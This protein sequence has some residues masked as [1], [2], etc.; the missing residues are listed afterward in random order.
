VVFCDDPCDFSSFAYLMLRLRV[1]T[2]LVAVAALPA[3]A[4]AQPAPGGC[5][6]WTTNSQQL[7]NVISTNHYLL[8]RNVQVDCNDMHFFADEVEVFSDADRVRASGHVVFVS[9]N[10][11]ISA[12]RMDFNTRTRTGTFYVA[13][14][15]ASLENRGVD[16]SYFGT[17]EPDAY[18][19]GQ[20]IEKLGPKRYRI[21]R[22]G[23][24]TCV[25]PTPRWELVSDSVTMTL[26]EHAVLTNAI[27][28]VKNVPLF[29]MPVM[30]YPI[31]KE[32]R[33]TGFLIPTY[34]TSTI[35]GHTLTNSFF[36]A[37][38][39]SQ[40]A[41]LEHDYFSKTGQGFGGE[42]R[43][44]EGPGSQGRVMVHY[45]KEHDAT[46]E[47]RNGS[48]SV[49]PGSS[50]YSFSGSM[51]QKLP[52]NLRL[53]A[54]ADY[55]S[56]VTAQQRYN[57]NIFAMTNR[58]RRINTS[59][60]G[61]WGRYSLTTT[62]DRAQTFNNETSWSVYGSAPRVNLSRA[63]TPIG[64]LPLYFGATSEYVTILR[65]D[66]TGAVQNDRGL[67][68]FD[69]YPTLRFPFT[70]WPFLTFNSSV[71]W[72]AT[73]WSESLD[74]AH[75]NI[76]IQEPIHRTYFD[77]S[78]RITGPVFTR[79][80]ST[81]NLGFA[82]KFK[83]VIEPT[84]TIQ[85]I[86][87][88]D[89]AD[90]IVKI[91]GTDLIVGRLTRVTYGL[92]NRLYAKKEQA[93]E[94][95][96]VQVSQSYYT[97]ANAAKQDAAYQSGFNPGLPPSHVSPIVVQ[98]HSAPTTAFDTTFRTEYDTQVHALRTIA[99]NGNFI[100]PWLTASA[101]WSQR[102]FIPRLPGYNNPLTATHY[103]NASANVRAPRNT[104]GG[105]YSFNYDLRQHFYLQ[106]RYMAYYNSQCCGVA[107][108]FQ[109]VNYGAAFAA[110]GVNQDHRFNISFTL[111]GIG[112]FSNLLGA[113][114]GQQVR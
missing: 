88:I 49:H 37:I 87:P 40:D 17:Q 101:G 84:V 29:Y 24:T 80:F 72:R 89:N 100:R 77:M 98:L 78:T 5:K 71:I 105:I 64:H 35:R 63:E 26:E 34:G 114:G 96:S 95:L 106:Q 2:I 62:V 27:L 61:N 93:R 54:N 45:I 99:A 83:H 59:L 8:L 19:W 75:R 79:I 22:G 91:D 20:T 16:R 81:P 32:D 12:E 50:S 69:A 9:N 38:N 10:N 55:F 70:R 48:T 13:S 25:Q 85:R 14:G 97:D 39:R 46:Y 51:G 110:I 92:N 56:S 94:I 58:S 21:T 52:A 4:A 111:A 60:S 3:V 112:T 36:W 102:R 7:R 42:Y 23:F 11:R 15:I 73:Y 90:K 107:V 74:T 18:F 43:Y 31:N 68:R 86:T 66:R 1:L 57:Q 47:Q 6:I 108:E 82:Q 65:E 76:Q 109:S 67:S 44:V 113:F 53:T 103:L 30:Y 33:A 41:T 28:K 104:F